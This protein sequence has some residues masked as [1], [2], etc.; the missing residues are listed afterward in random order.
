MLQLA[1]KVLPIN[2]QKI[3]DDLQSKVD[4]EADFSAK[5]EKAKNL[6]KT[7]GDTAG[8]LAFEK[9]SKILMDM[10]VSVKTCNY[11]EQNEAN[12]IEHI[13]PKSFFPEMSFRWNNYLLACKQCNSGYKLDK[14]FVIDKNGIIISTV[15]GEEPLHKIVALINPRI[16]DPNNFLWLNTAVWLFEVH[17]DLSHIDLNKATKT[18]EILELNN[19]DYLIE[20]RK[21][22]YGQIFDIMDRISRIIQSD[23]IQQIEQALAPYH[24]IIDTTLPIDDLKAQIIETTKQ[25]IFKLPHPSVWNA[26][27]TISSKIEPRWIEIFQI[28]PYANNW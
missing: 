15:R 9:I 1:D 26:I 11:C 16:E 21:N 20:G 7:K 13:Y 23:N 19:R 14:C 2:E 17:E 28:L 8:K 24:N 18:L 4:A 25:H 12:D 6:W 27:K 22:V 5:A 3:L 10:C